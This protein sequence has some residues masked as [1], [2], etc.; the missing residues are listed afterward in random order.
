MDMKPHRILAHEEE[1][2]VQVGGTLACVHPASQASVDLVLAADTESGDGRSPWVW[3][4]LPNGDLILGIFPQG[5][6]YFAVEMDAC[7]RD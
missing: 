1:D 6:T 3:L 2:I 7:F 4:R 5:E